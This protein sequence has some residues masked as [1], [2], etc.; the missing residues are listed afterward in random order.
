MCVCVCVCVCMCV[1]VWVYACM[2]M[3]VRV[4]VCVCVCVCVMH[5]IA[6]TKNFLSLERVAGGH[7]KATE[8]EI[9]THIIN[10]WKKLFQEGG[11]NKKNPVGV[12]VV[13]TEP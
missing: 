8:S 7:Q 5:T 3:C 2:C 11:L 10:T 4:C 13:E 9:R 12:N 1:S 6:K